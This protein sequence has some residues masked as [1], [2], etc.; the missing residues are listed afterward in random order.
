MT[1]GM[2]K[3]RAASED[4]KRQLLDA[5]RALLASEDFSRFSLESVARR[6][7]VSRLTIYYQFGSKRGL[8]EAL[9]DD[10]AARGDLLQ[11]PRIFSQRDP[12]EAL[13]SFVAVFCG[14]WASDPDLIRKL[15][16]AAALDSEFEAVIQRDDWRRN[17][18]KVLVTRIIEQRRPPLTDDAE[19]LVDLSCILT[20][21]ETFDGLK[22]A[23]WTQ[24]EVSQKVGQLLQQLL[25]V[26]S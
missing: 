13:Q 21:F 17:G 19:K 8:L 6:A 1:T 11:L 14:F 25:K 12:I 7:G 16:A 9:Y 26:D 4:T 22:R 5:A 23:G 24:E 3:R 18:L 2:D 20:S 10:L 15:R